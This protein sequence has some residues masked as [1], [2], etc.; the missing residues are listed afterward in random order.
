MFASHSQFPVPLRRPLLPVCVAFVAGCACGQVDGISTALLWSAGAMGFFAVL[1]WVVLG[2]RVKSRTATHIRAFAL[3]LITFVVAFFSSVSALRFSGK[4]N[5]EFWALAERGE[6]KPPFVGYIAT[7]PVAREMGGGAAKL[8]FD[9]VVTRMGNDTPAPGFSPV[10]FKT[11]WWGS[12]EIAG[13]HPPFVKPGA[14]EGWQFAG[15]M[16]T[17]KRR[18]GAPVLTFAV[19][20]RAG[21]EHNRRDESADEPMPQAGIWRMRNAVASTL[22]HG[23]EDNPRTVAIT[24][25][26][27]LGLRSEIPDEV[28]DFFRNSGTAHI[29]AI[30]G[31]HIGIA[32]KIIMLLIGVFAVGPRVR[33]LVFVPL[34]VAYTV[35]TGAA[36][37]AVRACLMALLYYCAPL[38]NRRPDSVSALCGAALIIL[39]VSP[40]QIT[41]VGFIFSFTCAAGILMMCARFG[42][43]TDGL[44]RYILNTPGAANIT[45]ERRKPP[46]W[47]RLLRRLQ[48]SF[49]V[50]LAALVFSTPIT[51]S[52]F[53]KIIPVSLLANLAVVPLSFAIV[54]TS[55]ASL[56]SGFFTLRLAEIFNHAN[57][58]LC[59][60][61]VK[62]SEWCANIP[63]GNIDVKNWGVKH[64]A[65]Y[66]AALFAL[67]HF[68]PKHKPEDTNDENLQQ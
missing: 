36:P 54:A 12:A 13:E 53:G 55:A 67:L 37:S 56:V 3:F 48:G 17:A 57:T 43:L 64:I 51:A 7:E 45:H 30:S 25:A 8:E 18:F 23:I 1:F 28:K 26:M 46:F 29:F 50:A 20:S 42:W 49:A 40:A 52:M 41:D 38:F 39:A 5:A 11:E 63:G 58:V 62:I 31:L 68:L 27:S 60:A 14:G 65:T 6:L 19:A 66:Y 16:K 2:I 32:A 61:A 21:R 24:K 9:F 4:K 35:M 22:A 10:R 44:N 15:S 33:V 34:I 47:E 59:G